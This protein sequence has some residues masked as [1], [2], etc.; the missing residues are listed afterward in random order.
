MEI[1]NEVD[2]PMGVV[3]FSVI[4]PVGHFRVL[5]A[6]T[7]AVIDGISTQ[8]KFDASSKKDAKTKA[9]KIIKR[10]YKLV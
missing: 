3:T 8:I 9:L 7:Y 10:I 4:T 1:T 6:D 5:A 2:S